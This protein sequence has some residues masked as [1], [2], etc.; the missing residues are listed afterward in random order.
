MLA[1]I[2]ALGLDLPK[3]TAIS[4]EKIRTILDKFNY[5]E[6]DV[7]HQPIFDLQ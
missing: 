1:T 3:N 6:D 2:C 5:W 4:K 7:D